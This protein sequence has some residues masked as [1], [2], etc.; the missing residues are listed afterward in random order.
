VEEKYGIDVKE[1]EIA[2]IFSPRDLFELVQKR[3]NGS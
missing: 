3:L 2:R 1:S